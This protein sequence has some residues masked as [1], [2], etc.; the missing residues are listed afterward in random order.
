MIIFTGGSSTAFSVDPAI[1]EEACSVPA[2]NFALPASAGA[3]FLLHQALEKTAPGDILVI[4]L[5]PD[6]LAFDSKYPSG[7]LAFG[8]AVL[9]GRPSAT[10]G[11]ETFNASLSLAEYLTSVRPGPKYLVTL[12]YRGAS[13]K[14][15][16]YSLDDYRY[17]GRM[18]TAVEQENLAPLKLDR[19][20]RLSSSGNHLLRSFKAKANQ[21]SVRLIYAMPWRWTLPEDVATSR[22][23]NA[24]LL[25]DISEIIE[26]VDD[27][28][29]G[30][31]AERSHFSDTPQHLTAAGSEAR[32]RALAP[33]L[34]SLLST[35]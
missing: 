5:E 27:G 26:V 16:R 15:Y 18:E 6:F 32:S 19:D 24:T 21:R 28:T 1:I 7:S 22:K 33:A 29:Y 23:A 30:V 14:G 9:D 12:L 3:H 10:V 20:V 13:R 35:P 31:S 4:G 8:L 11:G 34:K 17:H 2:F 25:S